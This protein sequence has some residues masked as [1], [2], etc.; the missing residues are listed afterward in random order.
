[1]IVMMMRVYNLNN[2]SL[3]TPPFDGYCIVIET[4]ENPCQGVI[5]KFFCSNKA[6]VAQ[7]DYC[8]FSIKLHSLAYSELSGDMGE[9][10]LGTWAIRSSVVPG[11]VT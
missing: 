3:T 9:T 4:S 11:S 2:Q 7:Q 8:N 1:M 5:C 6:G 10:K